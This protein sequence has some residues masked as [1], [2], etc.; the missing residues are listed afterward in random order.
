MKLSGRVKCLLILF[1]LIFSVF[2]FSSCAA[3]GNRQHSEAETGVQKQEAAAGQQAEPAQQESGPAEKKQAA[4]AAKAPAQAAQTSAEDTGD[5][6]ATIPKPFTAVQCGQ[7]HESIYMELRSNGGKHKFVCRNCHKQFHSY[8]PVR[9]NWNEIMPKC[10]SC[11]NQPH[12]PKVTEC[13]KCH[14]NPHTPLV[15]PYTKYVKSRCG[16]CHPGPA[17]ELKKYPS[18][19]TKLGC[20]RCHETHGQIPTCFKCHKPHIPNQGLAACKSCHPVHKPLQI[21]YGK[22]NAATC[23]TCHSGVYKEWK[24][25]KSKHGKVDCAQ[26]H[27][28]HGEIPKCSKCHGQPHDPAMLK[29]FKKCLDCHINVHDLPTG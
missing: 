2:L 22:G 10:S 4:E 16:K 5:V 13:L 18:K 15:I 14:Q 17:S 7:C 28:R 29:H 6:Y 25:T 20:A 12:G 3:T 1:S 26:C 21:T 27:P 9:N 8:N 11:H 24:H 19:H 23:A